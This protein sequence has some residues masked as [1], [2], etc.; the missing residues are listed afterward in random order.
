MNLLAK[1]ENNEV[2]HAVRAKHSNYT[3]MRGEIER[4]AHDRSE[5]DSTR[6]PGEIFAEVEVDRKQVDV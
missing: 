4:Q 1:F 5:E 3:D 2:K 6:Q